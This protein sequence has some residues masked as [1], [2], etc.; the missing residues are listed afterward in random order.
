MSAD[1]FYGGQK[2]TK[3][4]M[5]TKTG[6]NKPK[7]RLKADI[8]KDISAILGETVESMDKMTVNGLKQLETVLE[9]MYAET[10]AQ[11]TN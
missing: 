9:N 10:N 8:V 4:S 2:M 7:R 5:Q 6:V 1:R 11:Q 3:T